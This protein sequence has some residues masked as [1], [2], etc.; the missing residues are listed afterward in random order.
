MIL[1]VLMVFV[2]EKKLKNGQFREVGGISIKNIKIY[3]LNYENIYEKIL[4]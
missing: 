3:F 4:K 2:I 1:I